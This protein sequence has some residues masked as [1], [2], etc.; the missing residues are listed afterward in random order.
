MGRKAVVSLIAICIVVGVVN[1]VTQLIY[2]VDPSECTNCGL[3]IEVCPVE[4]IAEAEVDGKLV[5]VIDPALCTGCGLCSET[6]PVEAIS[7]VIPNEVL[8]ESTEEEIGSDG[9]LDSETSET[10]VTK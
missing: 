5:S 9:K 10:E 8:D 3:C 4:A 6:C 2:S 7:P 1:A